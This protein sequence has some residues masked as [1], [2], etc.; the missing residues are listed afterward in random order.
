LKNFT[1]FRGDLESL[2][3]RFFCACCDA[4]SSSNG[5]PLSIWNEMIEV[6][7]TA[8][9]LSLFP[10]RRINFKWFTIGRES[11]FLKCWLLFFFQGEFLLSDSFE[12]IQNS[13]KNFLQF[14]WK[15]IIL[16]LMKMKM[17]SDNKR[18]LILLVL[19]WSI[20]LI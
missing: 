10:F 20:S 14:F 4:F 16:N 9:D 8:F 5:G 18:N 7:Y 17:T 19:P 11:F 12:N 13:W 6:F 3:W 1:H 15:Q 2:R